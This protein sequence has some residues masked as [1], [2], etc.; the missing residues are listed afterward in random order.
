MTGL[1][2]GDGAPRDVTLGPDLGRVEAEALEL[3]G[4]L[5]QTRLHAVAATAGDAPLTGRLAMAAMGQ[6]DAT[7]FRDPKTFAIGSAIDHGIADRD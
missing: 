3:L 4:G 2:L 5:L 7:I 6:P 1:D